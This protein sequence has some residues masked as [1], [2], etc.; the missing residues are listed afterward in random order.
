MKARECVRFQKKKLFQPHG[1]NRRADCARTARARER[2]RRASPRRASWVRF[3]C[4]NV[5]AKCSTRL[6]TIQPPAGVRPPRAFD[7]GV[8]FDVSKYLLLSRRETR[9]ETRNNR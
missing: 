7:K 2:P 5:R 4:E 1:S 9:G 8:G 3:C 6:R